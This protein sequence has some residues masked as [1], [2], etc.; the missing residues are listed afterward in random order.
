MDNNTKKVVSILLQIESAIDKNHR[1]VKNISLSNGLLSFSL[2][3]YYYALYTG[4][5]DDIKKVVL[6]IEKALDMLTEEYTSYSYVNDLVELGIF[7]SFIK[8]KEF[9]EEVDPLLFQMDSIL[10]QLLKEKIKQKDID[11]ST[12]FP[13]IGKYFCYRDKIPSR[14]ELLQETIDQVAILAT[15]S[16]NKT[17]WTFNMRAQKNKAYVEL[18]LNHGVI[19]ITSYLLLLLKHEVYNDES[20]SL[21]HASIEYVLSFYDKNEKQITCFPVFVEEK[22]RYNYNNLAY[23]DLGIGYTIYYAGKILKNEKYMAQGLDII[24]KTAAF[25]DDRHLYIQEA[26][27]IYGTAGLASFFKKFYKETQIPKFKKASEYWFNE[28]LSYRNDNHQWAGFFAYYNSHLS[29]SHLCFCQGI[30]GIGIALM[31]HLIDIDKEY[32]NFLNY[33]L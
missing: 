30:A 5:E 26:G 3:Y 6:Y 10:K 29:T 11:L 24:L 31:E 17:Y 8:K 27:L 16:K 33:H 9:I 19:G 1:K 25:R 12:G 21:I 18:G 14:D 7:L 28:T 23:G 13:L 22:E 20:L 4:R 32:F 15:Y 2:F